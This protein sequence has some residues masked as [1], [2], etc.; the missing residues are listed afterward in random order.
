VPGWGDRARVVDVLSGGITNRNHLVEVDG[1]RFV[2]RLPGRDT[3]LLEIDRETERLANQR[4]ADLGFAPPVVGLVLGCLVTRFVAGRPLEPAQCSQPRV[5]T[6]VADCLRR[7][8]G[9]PPLAHTF[10]AFRVPAQHLA[11]AT[12]RGVSPPADYDRVAE[13]VTEIAAAFAVAPDPRCPCHNDLLSANLLDDNAHLWLLDWEY[14]GMNE[15]SFDL[16]NF[17]VNNDLDAEAEVEV[18]RTYHGTVTPRDLARLRLMKLVS[19]AREAMWAVVQQAIS[20]LE[21][22]YA[23]YADERFERLLSNAAAPGYA[24]LLADA[25]LPRRS[26]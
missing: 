17:A 1:E 23:S 5:V 11:A 16:G 14:A 4:A 9:T 20:T 18:V 25:A 13:I 3:D 7:F 6:A 24:S 10:D 2:V 15:P 26:S 22:D 8:H 19:D 12:A 21:F